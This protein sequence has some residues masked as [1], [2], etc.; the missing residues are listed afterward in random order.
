MSLLQLE[1]L[2]PVLAADKARFAGELD[3][4]RRGFEEMLTQFPPAPG[5]VFNEVTAGGVPAIWCIPAEAV[6]GRVLLYLHGGGYAVGSAKAYRLFVSHLAARLKA[7]V[8][9]PDYRLAPENPFPA[10]I[11]DAVATYRWLLDQGV[12]PHSFTIAGDS[13][14]GGLTVATLAAARDAGLP[15]PAGA[16][17]ISPWVDL[18]LS[19]ESIVS[20]A[21]EDT[22]LEVAALQGMAGAY[23]GATDPKTPSAS[24]LYANLAGLPPLLIQ[25]GSSELLLDDANRLAARAG[26]AGVKVRLEIWPSM[27][28]VWHVYGSRLDEGRDALNDAAA[29]L[30]ALTGPA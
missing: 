21:Q 2:Q 9:I 28:H 4:I 16:F 12:S 1:Q 23:L 3:Q 5:V 8:L 18:G 14:G 27:F 13:C 24:P 10:A 17:V 19:G 20:K 6:K 30:S 11:D 7:R 22:V 26:A 25:V 29:F 15:M